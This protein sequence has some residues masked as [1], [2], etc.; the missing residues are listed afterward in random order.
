MLKTVLTI[1]GSDSIGGAGIQGD[2]KTI[3][4][5]GCY[6]MSAVT[7]LTAQNTMGVDAVMEV[8]EDFF[9]AQL[10]SVFSDIF[11]DGV[12]IGMMSG[13][14]I[15]NAAADILEKY[16]AANIVTDTVMISTSGRRLLSEE[17]C[18]CLVKRIFPISRVITP[19]IPE[20]ETLTGMEIHSRSQMEK[21]AEKLAEYG[22]NVLLKGG[23]LEQC[24]ADLLLDEN[25][26]CWFESEKI[27]SGNTHGTGC[28]LSSAIAAGLAKGLS[29][30]ESTA[31]AKKYIT[32]AIADGLDI[33]K[34]NGPLNHFYNQKKENM[35]EL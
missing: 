21:A 28:T 3:S 15:I 14:A 27:P 22:C 8:P 12:K 24:A 11:P 17:G 32:G 7:A 35:N 13:I 19:N 2:I 30:R 31:T 20:A 4:A 34:G 10:E 1:A 33:G 26:F 18:R 9:R 23:H 25:G 5:L 6:G 29:L 16:N